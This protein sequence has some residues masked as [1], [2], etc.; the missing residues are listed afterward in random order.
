VVLRHISEAETSPDFV[1]FCQVAR[2]KPGQSL[3]LNL[4]DVARD[5][6]LALDDLEPRLLA[7]ADAGWLMY[8]PSGRDLSLTLLPPPSDAAERVATLL[9]RYATIQ[10][11]RV[12]EIAAYAQT[13]RCRHGYL[14]A[15]LGGRTIERCTV[16]DNCVVTA[17]ITVAETALPDEREQVLIVLRA[18]AESH[19]WGRQTLLH[20]L[21]GTS[22]RS[23]AGKPRLSLQ[24][25]LGFG[26]LA[27]RSKTALAALIDRLEAGSFLQGRTLDHGGVVLEITPA[28]RKALQNPA[29]LDVVLSPPA[30]VTGVQTTLTG[31]VVATPEPD[32]ALLEKLTDWRLALAK[33]KKVPVYVI[34]NNQVLEAIAV[35]QPTTREALEKIKGIGPSKMAHYGETIVELVKAHL[36]ESRISE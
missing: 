10:A 35:Q 13:G 6:A 8:L 18:L 1:A 4:C 21:R 9:E 14:N 7:W 33:Q 3:T 29:A 11:Q 16:C 12:D 30:P 34:F 28:G 31:E 23:V 20:L 36:E 24:D 17:P 27:F 5:L 15:Y 26:A 25:K 32:A 19:G 22:P 2:L